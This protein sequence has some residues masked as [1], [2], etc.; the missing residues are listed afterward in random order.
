MTQ[1]VAV[2]ISQPQ[3]LPGSDHNSSPDFRFSNLPSSGP[4]RVEISDNPNASKISFVLWENINNRQDEKIKNTFNDTKSGQG[5]TYDASKL[6]ESK[7]YYIGDPENAG[8]QN[9]KVTFV[10]G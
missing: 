1:T 4:V 5:S 9:F 10:A 2:I 3:P 8:G 7:N 6:D